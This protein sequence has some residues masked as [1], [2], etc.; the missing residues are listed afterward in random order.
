MR[1]SLRVS[2]SNVLLAARTESKANLF[3]TWTHPMHDSIEHPLN[4][5]GRYIVVRGLETT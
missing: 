4:L 3:L 2:V 5:P 1:G